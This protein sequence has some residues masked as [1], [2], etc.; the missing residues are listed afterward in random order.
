MNDGAGT[1]VLTPLFKWTPLACYRTP[2][3][4]LRTPLCEKVGLLMRNNQL[5]RNEAFLQYILAFFISVSK[6]H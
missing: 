6:Y 1:K 5:K 4:Y 3:E 2:I